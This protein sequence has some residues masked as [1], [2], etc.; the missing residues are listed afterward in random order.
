MGMTASSGE[1]REDCQVH[2]ASLDVSCHWGRGISQVLVGQLVVIRTDPVHSQQTFSGQSAGNPE[3]GQPHAARRSH[4][5][6]NDMLVTISFHAAW[7][8]IN[9]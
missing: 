2:G 6:R 5:T 7:I 8:K 9:I 3:T 1:S 4:R